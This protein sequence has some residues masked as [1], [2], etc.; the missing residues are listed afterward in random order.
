[1]IET[2]CYGDVLE[3]QTISLTYHLGNDVLCLSMIACLRGDSQNRSDLSW[4]FQ[5]N[6]YQSSD[7]AVR[8]NHGMTECEESHALQGYRESYTNGLKPSLSY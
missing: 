4:F 3:T 6:S 7:L 5:G 1:M 8:E 2:V